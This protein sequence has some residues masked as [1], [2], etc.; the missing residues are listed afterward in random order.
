MFFKVRY[1]YIA[2]SSKAF[3]NI[4]CFHTSL[5]NFDLKETISV[6]AQSV[7]LRSSTNS[8]FSEDKHLCGGWGGDRE[9][10]KISDKFFPQKTILKTCLELASVL[11]QQLSPHQLST[12]HKRVSKLYLSTCSVSSQQ[13]PKQYSLVCSSAFCDFLELLFKD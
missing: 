3:S 2:S 1:F 4:S 10:E 9:E 6:W 11:R 7:A 5:D 12:S 8:C 13:V